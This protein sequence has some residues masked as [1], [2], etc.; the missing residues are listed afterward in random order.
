MVVLDEA[1]CMVKLISKNFTVLR[2][3]ILKKFLQGIAVSESGEIAVA[4]NKE[5]DIYEG[6][7]RSNANTSITL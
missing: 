6:D 4:F 1:N 2:S 5:I 7:P 3:V